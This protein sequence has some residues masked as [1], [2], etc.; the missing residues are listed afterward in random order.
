MKFVRI[1]GV[2]LVAVSAVGLMYAF[3]RL[4]SGPLSSFGAVVAFAAVADQPAVVVAYG[5]TGGG[6]SAPFGTDDMWQERLAAV[7]LDTG[8]LLWDVQLHDQNGWERAVLAVADGLA[9]VAT[10]YGLS[11]VATEDGRIVAQ[12]DQIRGLGDDY[13]LAYTAYH[14]DPRIGAVVALT[15]SGAVVAI[16]LGTTDA[17]PAPAEVADAWRGTLIA[18]SAATRDATFVMNDVDPAATP[19]HMV[20]PDGGAVHLSR[21]TGTLT[22]QW[23]DGRT[24]VLTRIDDLDRPRLVYDIVRTPAALATAQ[25]L[26]EG[27]TMFT[28]HHSA[29]AELGTV[30]GVVLV[31]GDDPNGS[32]RESLRL[33]DI[34]S[35]ETVAV[36]TDLYDVHRATTTPGGDILVF[37][38]PAP[39]WFEH[40][41]DNRLIVLR[42]D[43]R[44]T[45]TDIGLTDFWG[46]P[47]AETRSTDA[48]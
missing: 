21:Q 5:R 22:R 37:A 10:D 25:Q 31:R 43:G 41:N 1:A 46:R 30:N 7:S 17:A 42:P 34:G 45:W 14:V 13:A 44:V 36:V 8:E 29:A 2:L 24:E 4:V 32:G 39:G 27:T 19:K 35:G 12:N 16:P 6:R 20:L 3:P 47:R 9:Y 40:S 15:R 28:K 26:G 23:P 18:D 33:I 48:C 38:T 11:I